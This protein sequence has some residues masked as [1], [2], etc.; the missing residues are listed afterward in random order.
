MKDPT[1]GLYGKPKQVAD[2]WVKFLR[3]N[4]DGTPPPSVYINFCT[5][6]GYCSVTGLKNTVGYEDF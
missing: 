1:F 5:M 4:P 3:N 6:R 2:R